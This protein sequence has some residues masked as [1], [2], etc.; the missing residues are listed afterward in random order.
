MESEVIVESVEPVDENNVHM[1]QNKNS[2]KINGTNES[3][4]ED[5]NSISECDKETKKNGDATSLSRSAVFDDSTDV[6]CGFKL[7]IGQIPKV[8]DDVEFHE[9]MEQFGPVLEVY[10]MRDSRTLASKGC[11]FVTYVNKKDADMAKGI[12]HDKVTLANGRNLLQVKYVDEDD[13]QEKTGNKIFVGMLPYLQTDEERKRRLKNLFEKFGTIIEIHLIKDKKDNFKGCAFIK[14]SVPEAADKAIEVMAGSIPKGHN[15]KMI[16]KH[17]DMRKQK[18]YDSGQVADNIY[19][20]YDMVDH[21]SNIGTGIDSSSIPVHATPPFWSNQTGEYSNVS[22]LSVVHPNRHDLGAHSRDIQIKQSKNDRDPVFTKGQDQGSNVFNGQSN[23]NQMMQGWDVSNINNQEP[24]MFQYPSSFKGQH[25]VKDY[26]IHTDQVIYNYPTQ[27]LYHNM[28]PYNLAD[29]LVHPNYK[30]HGST[31]QQV[32]K[33]GR[34]NHMTNPQYESE[35]VISNGYPQPQQS[36]QQTNFKEEA[37]TSQGGSQ[38]VNN[39][40]SKTS[41]EK[42][43]NSTKGRKNL[44]RPPEGPDGANLFV[45]HLPWDLTDADLA[46]L[47]APFGNVISA[48]VYL[49]KKTSK[50][51]GFGFVSYDSVHSAVVAIEMMNGFQISDKRLTVQV[52]RRRNSG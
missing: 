5:S 35:E 52:K 25:Q 42:S 37:V 33:Q 12:L 31:Y 4:A 3:D 41:N 21:Y 18:K 22:Y 34:R 13:D 2:M 17:A 30:S 11:A 1:L 19:F 32:H 47:F 43:N 46:T 20:H 28:M 8:M 49:D 50:S 9:Y 24:Q 6:P 7:F 44:L 23:F 15:R 45:Y 36:Q 38:D 14:F 29:M 39:I 26:H 16:V 51:R 10:M 48:K 27:N 40:S